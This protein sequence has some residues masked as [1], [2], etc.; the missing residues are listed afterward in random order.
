MVDIS[1]EQQKK[2]F[3]KVV[4]VRDNNKGAEKG[5]TDIKSYGTYQDGVSI[6][7]C[8]ISHFKE[9]RMKKRFFTVIFIILAVMLSAAELNPSSVVIK[10][11]SIDGYNIIKYAAMQEWGTDHEM[12][13]YEINKQCESCLN[14]LESALND[15]GE[16]S[17]FMDAIEEW[18]VLGA[19][20]ANMIIINGWL[21]GVDFYTIFTMQC[22]WSMVEYEYNKQ[23]ETVGSY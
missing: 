5:S 9:K 8:S 11:N 18:S 12:V 21:E 13:L 22:D 10:R 4:Q 14:V 1:V 15:D 19:A 2:V 20:L 3:I 23:M 16:F 7:P 6:P 17:I